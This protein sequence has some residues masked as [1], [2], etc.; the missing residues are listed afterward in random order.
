MDKR[1]T[2]DAEVDKSDGRRSSE[3]KWNRR[4]WPQRLRGSTVPLARYAQF[5]RDKIRSK[6]ETMC[7]IGGFYKT[8]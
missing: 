4:A 3:V 5:T 2:R 7:K 6:G 8:R 1:W